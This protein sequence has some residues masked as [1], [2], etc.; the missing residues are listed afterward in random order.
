MIATQVKDTEGFKC[1]MAVMITAG[2]LAC[3][4][5]LI[6]TEIKAGSR[7]TVLVLTGV[8]GGMVKD[9]FGYYFGSSEGSQRK[10]EM[11]KTEG[12]GE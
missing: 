3:I 7:E 2:F 4:F 12:K 6:H 11:L 9:V 1:L 10:T 5:K 8:L